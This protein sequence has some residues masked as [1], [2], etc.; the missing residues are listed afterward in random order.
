MKNSLFLILFTTNF[1]A[2]WAY[3]FSADGF[4][5]NFYGDGDAV[6]LVSPVEKKTKV[7]IPATV[8]YR[9]REFKIMKIGEG[10]FINNNITELTIDEGIQ[11]I[12][13]EAF[14]N[15]RFSE[16]TI[17]TTITWAL[18]AEAFAYNPE[19]KTI[20]MNLNVDT[21]HLIPL[22]Y[23]FKG[24]E[25]IE[26]I[27][28][29]N[30]KPI[31]GLSYWPPFEN[32]VYKFANVYVPYNSY[33]RYK[34]SEWSKKFSLPL[35]PYLSEGET[36]S[37]GAVALLNWD[38]S[39]IENTE[40]ITI[41]YRNS[42]GIIKQGTITLDFMPWNNNYLVRLKP[43][44]IYLSPDYYFIIPTNEEGEYKYK[45][46]TKF[47]AHPTYD[48][49]SL[50]FDISWSLNKKNERKNYVANVTR[51]EERCADIHT[52]LSLK[53]PKDQKLF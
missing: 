39:K 12:G 40:S 52:K 29:G 45:L 49:K 23:T 19:L 6:I 36:P 16:L 47:V 4:N 10:A 44:Y 43:S 20:R 25:N 53:L 3:D 13:K 37:P 11:Y 28:L 18:G 9:N 33:F 42:E 32:M 30:P 41:E 34:D 5:F 26:N 51:K 7:H 48:N 31:E 50:E 27:Y 21:E 15:N 24:C 46:P 38:D 35:I 8:S 22:E 17:P 14:K 1:I 2:S